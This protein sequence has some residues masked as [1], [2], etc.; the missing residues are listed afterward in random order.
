MSTIDEMIKQK[1]AEQERLAKELEELQTRKKEEEESVVRELNGRL[2]GLK[3]K[4]LDLET[5][6]TDLEKQLEKKKGELI[7]A[8]NEI[9]EIQ[10]KLYELKEPVTEVKQAPPVVPAPSEEKVE[11]KKEPEVNAFDQAFNEVK[12]TGKEDTN[13]TYS[14][15]FDFVESR[16]SELYKLV[17][18]IEKS[19]E[20]SFKLTFKM[21]GDFLDKMSDLILERNHIQVFAITRASNMIQRLNDKISYIKNNNLFILPEE[22]V[23]YI[24]EVV[25]G[26]CITLKTNCFSFL[27]QIYKSAVLEESS[28][29]GTWPLYNNVL[30]TKYIKSIQFILKKFYNIQ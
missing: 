12:N 27:M 16:D 21:A 22:Q 26:D 10:S 15:A 29:P 9:R 25:D 24:S 8:Q 11:K 14:N 23:T 20:T 6:I 1:L 13:Y 7:A 4:Q 19:G 3:S 17:D 30:M 5:C 2:N 28:N 18:D